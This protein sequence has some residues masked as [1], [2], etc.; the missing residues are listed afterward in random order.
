MGQAWGSCQ[1]QRNWLVGQPAGWVQVTRCWPCSPVSPAG[2]FD[3][4]IEVPPPGAEA[5]T[6]FFLAT[7][8]RPEIASHLRC[9]SAAVA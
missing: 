8:Q 9:G 5:R 4:K 2:R 6:A 7:V 3:R 1:V